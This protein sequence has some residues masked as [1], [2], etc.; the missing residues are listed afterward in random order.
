[1]LLLCP[2]KRQANTSI[3]ENVMIQAIQAGVSRVTI[4]AILEIIK[5]KKRIRKIIN[6]II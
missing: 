1:M 2:P 3:R 6:N 4:K 5:A